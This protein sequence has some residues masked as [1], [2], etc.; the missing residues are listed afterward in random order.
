MNTV[1]SAAL[2]RKST[3]DYLIQL[4]RFG[5]IGKW[6]VFFCF[7]SFRKLYEYIEAICAAGSHDV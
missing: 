2:H 7:V 5:F 4:S 6:F 3:G 1:G